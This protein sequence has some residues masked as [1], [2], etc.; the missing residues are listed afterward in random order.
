M[1][2]HFYLLNSLRKSV[3]VIHFSTS[4]FYDKVEEVINNAKITLEEM[5][6]RVKESG[7][8]SPNE[9]I[10]FFKTI[11]PTVVGILVF[12]IEILN[13]KK[14]LNVGIKGSTTKF[15]KKQILMQKKYLKKNSDFYEYWI[16]N[17]TDLDSD[18]F[19]TQPSLKR[20]QWNHEMIPLTLDPV[21][22][23]SHDLILGKIIG[24]RKTIDFLKEYTTRSKHNYSLE[25]DY[26]LKWTGSKVDLV[27]LIYA[28]HVSG[29]INDGN[30]RITDLTNAF[31][32]IFQIELKNIYRSFVEIQGR[33]KTPIKFLKTLK[34]GLIEKIDEAME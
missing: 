24:I 31:Q 27:E 10:L 13:L 18:Y 32:Q 21:F 3:P 22:N 11:K 33:K 16:R 23:T 25:Q 5:R 19:R 4:D 29:V 17:K 1:K 20:W 28:L 7:F 12:H 15:L 34:S 14:K 6:L 9:E 8:N 2:K 30:S 26:H